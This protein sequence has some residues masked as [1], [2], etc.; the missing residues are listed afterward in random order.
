MFLI[1]N[2]KM[3]FIE[4]LHQDKIFKILILIHLI[5]KNNLIMVFNKMKYLSIRMII[6]RIMN[7]IKFK[8]FKKVYFLPQVQAE[9]NKY[10]AIKD[11]PYVLLN[12]ITILMDKTIVKIINIINFKIP[13]LYHL[14]INNFNK[15]HRLNIVLNQG[16][17]NHL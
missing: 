11:I 5:M 9:N 17:K 12:K 14:L 7:K 4:T 6:I 8:V 16:I 15:K 2:S 1:T 13:Q 3:L 10:L